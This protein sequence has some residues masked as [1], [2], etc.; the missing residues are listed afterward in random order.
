MKESIN[1]WVSRLYQRTKQR[2][3]QLGVTL[4]EVLIGIAIAAVLAATSVF[5]GARFIG[6]GQFSS[7]RGTLQ[8]AILV[9]EQQYSKI[10]PGGQRNYTGEPIAATETF[11]T[12]T[13]DAL[14]NLAASGETVQFKGA[15]YS[16]NTITAAGTATT[17]AAG[18]L[19]AVLADLGEGEVWIEVLPATWTATSSGLAVHA[20]AIRLGT[21]AGNGAT[22]CAIVVKQA[23]DSIN[24]G[25]A[26]QSAAPGGTPATCGWGTEPV[27]D[28]TTPANTNLPSNSTDYSRTL[29]EPE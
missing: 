27:H 17:P 3:D 20:Q 25:R 22:L 16:S 28:T 23:Q 4:Q 24:L 18:S 6:T 19:E 12:L 15:T 13:T 10:L 21:K 2:A 7:A 26:Y 29:D 14:T 5:L 9:T 11:Q 1:N 8:S